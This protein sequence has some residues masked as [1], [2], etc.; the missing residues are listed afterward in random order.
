MDPPATA[1]MAGD[2]TLFVG[3]REGAADLCVFAPS[4]L[5][6]GLPPSTPCCQT[7]AEMDR[8]PHV[9]PGDAG[10]EDPCSDAK[11]LPTPDV[12]MRA[13]LHSDAHAARLHLRSLLRD[14]DWRTQRSQQAGSLR[15]CDLWQ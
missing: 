13:L 11:Y 10:H 3:T 9:L 15:L 7:T 2:A 5:P 12:L 6:E 4:K 1:S 8:E 14:L